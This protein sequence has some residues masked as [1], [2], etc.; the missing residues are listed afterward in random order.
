MIIYIWLA[1]IIYQPGT[2]KSKI[3]IGPLRLPSTPTQLAI[4]PKLSGEALWNLEWELK[5]SL[6]V[7]IW[8]VLHLSPPPNSIHQLISFFTSFHPSPYLPPSLIHHL[9]H[10]PPHSIHHLIYYLFSLIILFHLAYHSI[11]HPIFY[12]P[13]P[14]PTP[15]IP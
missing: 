15:I 10:P 4:S 8:P 2:T 11:H 13:F 7:I 5:L 6:Q 12:N 9:S 1:I 14:K 3:T